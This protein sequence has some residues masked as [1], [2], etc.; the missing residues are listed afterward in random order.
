MAGIG[1]GGISDDTA[2][3]KP[4][5]G[6]FR[7]RWAGNR[8]GSGSCSFNNHGGESLHQ[9]F[10]QNGG[11]SSSSLFSK[12]GDFTSFNNNEEEAVTPMP[13]GAFVPLD[14]PPQS[15]ASSGIFTAAP[16]PPQPPSVTDDVEDPATA[17]VRLPIFSQLTK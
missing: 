8:V 13:S 3:L 10:D 6:G 7:D 2:L 17:A 16:S 5:R 4:L 12:R 9:M 15:R 14:P 1:G 11:N